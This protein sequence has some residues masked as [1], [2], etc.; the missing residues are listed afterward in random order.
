MGFIRA[1]SG[2]VRIGDA[3]V[4]DAPGTHVMPQHRGVGY[5]AQEGALFPHLSVGQNVGFGLPRSTRKSGDRINEVLEH[6][7]ADQ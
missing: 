5:V 7:G 1:D 6:G 3:V 4:V 2:Q